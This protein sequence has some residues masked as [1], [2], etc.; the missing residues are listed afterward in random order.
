[1]FKKKEKTEKA[2]KNK[3]VRT[4]KV[5]THK[6]SVLLLWAVLLAS[7][8]FGVY[9]NFTAI[10]T[11]TVHEKEIIQ[12]RL[13][14]TNGIENFV[15]NF[16]KAYYSWDTSKEA[17]EA[18][19]TEISKYLTKELQ[20][21]NADTIRTDIPTSA[22][23]TN[24]LV[25]NVEQSGTDDFTVAYEVDQQIKEGEQT[26]NVK[27]TYTVKV[28][29]DADGDMV[30][31]Q[32]PTLAPAVEK[33]DYE[34][35]T[36]EA[37]ASVDADTVNDATAFLETFFKLYPTATEKELAYYVLGNVI[38]PIGRDYLY[39]ELVNPIFIKDGDNVKVKVAVKFI[40]NQTKATQVSQYELVLHKDSNWKIVG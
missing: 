37:D 11:H 39:S 1:M 7:T 38:E 33:S 14:D 17:I 2:P 28:Y 4:M 27:A 36:P 6:K 29:V 35:K 8:S 24:V 3:K 31:V 12:L 16:A 18:R 22:T 30:I 23:V 10:D 19:T 40:D 25:W 15:K 32:N 5:G 20:D 9:K 13:N 21:L 26:S 34:P